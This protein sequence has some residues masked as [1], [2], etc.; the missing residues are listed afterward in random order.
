MA[1]FLLMGAASATAN[2]TGMT[3]L[4][5]AAPPE[6]RGAAMALYSGCL[7]AGQALGPALSGAVA[8]LGGWRSA[9]VTGAVLGLL[10]AVVSLTWRP[11]ARTAGGARAARTPQG[12]P[13]TTL[14]RSVVSAV[15]FAVFLTVGAMPQT[16]LPL[17]GAGEL[18]LSVT[19]IGLALGLGGLARIVSAVAAGAVSDRS[20]PARRSPPLPRPADS[21][22]APPGG[23]RR[24]RLV[25]GCDRAHVAGRLR[26]RRRG[27]RARRPHRPLLA[28]TQPREVT[29]SAPTSAWS[30]GPAL[31]AVVYESW[32]RVAAVRRRRRGASWSSPRGGRARASRDR[33]PGRPPARRAGAGVAMDLVVVIARDRARRLRQ[34]RHRH[35]AAADRHPRHGDRG[36]RRAGGHDHGHPR[37]RLEPVAGRHPPRRPPRDPRPRRAARRPA[38]SARSLGTVALT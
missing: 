19:A 14:Q 7:L 15:G 4:S 33:R 21:R 25:A 8:G 30:A 16:V 3:T 6:R 31:A 12:P 26:A 23:R 24:H 38:S 22:S 11:G 2:T 27:D 32:G 9:A 13:L 5:G 10:V 1:S 35:R 28:R 36:R 29:A 37:H 20:L 17:V 34:G 18:G